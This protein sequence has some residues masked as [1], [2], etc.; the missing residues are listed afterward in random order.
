MKP[1]YTE[2]PKAQENFEEAMKA[3]FRVPKPTKRG[4]KKATP[5]CFFA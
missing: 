3:I 4:K 1:E 2:G 5:F